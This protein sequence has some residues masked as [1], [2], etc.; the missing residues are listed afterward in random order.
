MPKPS[1]AAR[2]QNRRARIRSTSIVAGLAALALTAAACSSSGG[3]TKSG[4]TGSTGTGTGSSGA[5]ALTKITVNASFP[6]AAGQYSCLYDYGKA[7]GFFAKYGVDPTFDAANGSVALINEVAAGQVDFGFSAAASNVVQAV[8]KGAKV[9]IIGVQERESP[10]AVISSKSNPIT[11]PA[12]L[13]GKKIAYGAATLAGLG[14]KLLLSQ[15]GMS[16]S[17]VKVINVQTT[18]YASSL[19]SG[20]IDGF[21][22]YPSSAFPT[23][24]SLG[25]QPQAMLLRDFGFNPVPADTYIA[26][27]SFIAAHADVVKDFLAGVHDTWAYMAANSG[28]AA[29][30]AQNC[31]GKHVGVSVPQ[32]TKQIQLVLQ[33]NAAQLADKNFEAVDGSA[34]QAQIDLLHKAGQLP[35]AQPA[36]SYFTN[37]YLPGSS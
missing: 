8:S 31:V 12:D 34:L 26:S 4:S 25:V 27:D 9:K 10:N 16:L 19:K 23:L 15:N 37:A 24:E 14:L 32:A 17:D 30:A 22:S 36:A 2:A 20:A 3:A 29:A 6:Y 35:D 28:A 33:A 11:K 21:V 13:K 18:A 1:N 5:K 7:K